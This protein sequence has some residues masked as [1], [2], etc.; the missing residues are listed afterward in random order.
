M[1]G[2]LIAIIEYGDVMNFIPLPAI[3]WF[4]HTRIP[5]FTKILKMAKTLKH[6][7]VLELVSTW[8]V[9]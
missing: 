2:A 8:K 6:N 1:K 5:T 9:R 7:W 3:N 4:E